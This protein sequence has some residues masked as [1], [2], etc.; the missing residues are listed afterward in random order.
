[1]KFR[2]KTNANVNR[3]LNLDIINAVR[4]KTDTFLVMPG[5]SGISPEVYRDVIKRGINKINYLTYMSYA[6]FSEA[7]TFLEGKESGFYHDVAFAVK[8]A[9]KKNVMATMMVFSGK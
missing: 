3:V 5:G 7:K 9:M 4:A 1:M 2:Q 8:E 6:G